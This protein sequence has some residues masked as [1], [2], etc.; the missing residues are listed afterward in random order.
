ML[1]ELWATE[2]NQC[3]KIKHCLYTHIKKTEKK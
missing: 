3:M 2:A 1:Y